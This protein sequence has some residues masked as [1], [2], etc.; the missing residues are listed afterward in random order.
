MYKYK[1]SVIIPIYNVENYL[2]DAIDS[3]INQNIGFSENIQLILINDGS[4]DNSES[5]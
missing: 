4:K 1:F 3:V 5:I 2:R